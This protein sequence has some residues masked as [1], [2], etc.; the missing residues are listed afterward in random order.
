[1]ILNRSYHDDMKAFFHPNVR[2]YIE[3][4]AHPSDDLIYLLPYHACGWKTRGGKKKSILYRNGNICIFT[5]NFHPGKMNVWK[6]QPLVQFTRH[7]S[8]VDEMVKFLFNCKGYYIYN[9]DTRKYVHLSDTPMRDRY[10][11]FLNAKNVYL[12]KHRKL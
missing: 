1:M 3:R 4:T 7:M 2:R 9:F 5:G 11:H 8:F 12:N 10:E 6:F